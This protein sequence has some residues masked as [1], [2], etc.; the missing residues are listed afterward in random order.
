MSGTIIT[1]LSAFAVFI[2][3]WFVLS[4]RKQQEDKPVTYVC[5]EC[6]EKNCNCYREDEIPKE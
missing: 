6:G 3:F 5:M 4:R 1:I 2:I